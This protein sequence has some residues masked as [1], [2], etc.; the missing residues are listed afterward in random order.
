MDTRP[1]KKFFLQTTSNTEKEN[2]FKSSLS[3]FI[4][5][6]KQAV[7][8]CTECNAARISGEIIRT[9]SSFSLTR[10][11]IFFCPVPPVKPKATCNSLGNAGCLK[12]VMK[13]QKVA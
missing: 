10:P 11:S 8:N 6:L 12:H 5:A 7:V 4:P 1:K 13:K 3:R 9:L 2:I